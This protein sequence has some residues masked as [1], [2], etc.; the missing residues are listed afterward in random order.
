MRALVLVLLCG[1]NSAVTVDDMST[2]DLAPLVQDVDFA[3][4][5]LTTPVDMATMP[6]LAWTDLAGGID[7]AQPPDMAQPVD[8]AHL[9]P[10]M[11]MCPA[12]PTCGPP[13][14]QLGCCNAALHCINSYCQNLT[15]EPCNTNPAKGK[16]VTC[17]GGKACSAGGTCQ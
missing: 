15:G 13:L 8:L 17:Y 11:A 9:A 2:A 3:G 10:D 1:C 5:D 4:V 14:A 6:D 16:V 12:V 7:I